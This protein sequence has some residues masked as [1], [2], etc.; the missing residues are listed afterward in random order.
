MHCDCP[1]L[2]PVC[3]LTGAAA[4]MVMTWAIQSAA[5]STSQH[6]QQSA[7]NLHG[8]NFE[9]IMILQVCRLH[10]WHCVNP[11]ITTC[12]QCIYIYIV[13]PAIITCRQRAV[14]G[15]CG[16]CV[17][18]AILGSSVAFEVR[19]H[20]LQQQYTLLQV[21]ALTV[22]ADRQT[23]S[24]HMLSNVFLCLSYPFFSEAHL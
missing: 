24:M 19:Q 17:G 13:N 21:A 3:M 23:G 15:A 16:W 22:S 14:V 20:L 5:C 1:P 9:L 6:L 11:A 2:T 12:R 7:W 18:H 10:H 8:G 4:Q